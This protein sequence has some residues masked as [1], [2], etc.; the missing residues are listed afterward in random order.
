MLARPITNTGTIKLIGKF[1]SIKLGRIVW[2]ESLLERDYLYL[3][4]IDS[5]VLYYQEQPGRIYYTIGGKNHHYTPDLLV[6]RKRI[7]EIIEVKLKAKSEEE[8][9]V[10]L[11]Q[12]ARQVCH[13]EACEFRVATEEIIRC[14]PKL[15][16]TK[17]L[18]K[19][20]LTPIYPQHQI[21]CYEFFSGKHEAPL[22][23]VMQFFASRQVG[24]Q[25]VY[26]L[27]YYGVLS[28]DLMQPL[29]PRS[30]VRLPTTAIPT[31]KDH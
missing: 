11:F 2:Y 5:D 16:N 21:G 27:I 26:A 30:V 4:E 20:A 23:E 14:Q 1:P 7:R 28:I 24:Q 18:Y 25:V 3:L 10:R 8:H 9:Y 12:I 22:D 17:L 13:K 15:D 6:H 29:T 19:Y 31:R